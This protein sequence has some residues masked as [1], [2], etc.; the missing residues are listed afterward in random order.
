MDKIKAEYICRISFKASSDLASLIH[1]SKQEDK[2]IYDALKKSTKIISEEV[3]SKIFK[4]F[5]EI[6]KD[7]DIF[8]NE[9]HRLP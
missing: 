1:I 2:E 8:I 4:E 3:I 9:F 6:K 5:P 7:F